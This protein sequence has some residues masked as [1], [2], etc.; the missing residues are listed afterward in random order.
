MTPR[1]AAWWEKRWYN[2]GMGGLTGALGGACGGWRIRE[3]S[4]ES[5]QW[6]LLCGRDAH[7]G[8]FR[9]REMQSRERRREEEKKRGEEERRVGE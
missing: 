1:P 8:F 4:Q 7:G 5:L 3:M 9:E 2:Q 6:T